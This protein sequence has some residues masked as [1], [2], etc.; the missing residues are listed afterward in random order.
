MKGNIINKKI[1][2]N[3]VSRTDVV[4]NFAA[5]SHVDR[6]ISDPRP[7]IDSNIVGMY[8]ILEA[9]KKHKKKLIQISTDEVLEVSSQIVRMR[10]FHLILPALMQHQRHQQRCW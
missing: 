4:I 9:I 10:N 6:S 7:F 8:S 2:D 3:L 1:V 5:E